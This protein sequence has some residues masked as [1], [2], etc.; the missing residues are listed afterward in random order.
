MLILIC[1]PWIWIVYADTKSQRQTEIS[2]GCCLVVFII[3]VPWQHS[4]KREKRYKFY[5]IIAKTEVTYNRGIGSWGFAW[6]FLCWVP[7]YCLRWSLH[8]NYCIYPVLLRVNGYTSLVPPLLSVTDGAGA[9]PLQTALALAEKYTPT[10]T[11][12]GSLETEPVKELVVTVWNH[13]SHWGIFCQI[14]PF[15][16]GPHF[17]Q[18]SMGLQTR[19]LSDPSLSSMACLEVETLNVCRGKC[20]YLGFFY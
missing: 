18:Q 20:K 14:S 3:F 8:L 17:P 12:T 5:F 4:F 2:L 1:K 7:L 16:L 11:H 6:I 15:C 10:N 13:T 19:K 9:E